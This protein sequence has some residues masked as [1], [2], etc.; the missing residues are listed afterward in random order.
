[1][2]CSKST[3]KEVLLNPEPKDR[4]RDNA[5]PFLRPSPAGHRLSALLTIL[6]SIPAS[7]EALLNRDLLRK[8]Y[9]RHNEWWDGA[10]IKLPWTFDEDESSSDEREE[11]IYETQRLMAFLSKTDRAYGSIDA[12]TNL[13]RIKGFDVD[14][15]IPLYLD[16][17]KGATLRYSP[18]SIQAE[19]FT[20][21]AVRVT[22]YE[23]Q[24]P[25]IC[26]LDLFVNNELADSGQ[27]LYDALDDTLWPFNDG[28]EFEEVYLEKVADV[29]VIQVMRQSEDGSGIGIKVPATW[30]SDRYLQSSQPVV[31]KM[32]EDKA[33]LK[34]EIVSLEA[35]KAKS[36]RFKMPG[37]NGRSYDITSLLGTT[38]SFFDK[39]TEAEKSKPNE[40]GYEKKVYL[41]QELQKVLDKV[42]NKL[43]GTSNHIKATLC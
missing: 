42:T 9:G 25:Q 29:L 4:K 36:M 1:M 3:A 21:R 28:T 16:A 33:S 23:P 14:Q 2:T 35:E 18:N 10:S 32:M 12:L 17:W 20:T 39:M 27:T 8:E 7:R 13:S 5:V 37:V 34:K 41:A 30:Y 31:R 24:K 26:C 6:H 43:R 15:L 38:K 11:I 22:A 40:Q 19:I